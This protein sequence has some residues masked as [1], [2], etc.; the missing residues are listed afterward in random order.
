MIKTE[1]IPPLYF[2]LIFYSMNLNTNILEI[3]FKVIWNWSAIVCFS[4]CLPVYLAKKCWIQS[5]DLFY[6]QIFR[7]HSMKLIK[8]ILCVCYLPTAVCCILSAACFLISTACYL[9][10]AVFFLLSAA[11]SLLLRELYIWLHNFIM[12][13]S[14]WLSR[15]LKC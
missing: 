12:W 7:Y 1:F 2:A 6:I 3:N 9:M 8:N 5:L 14:L 11:C 15:Y 4:R 13:H 10:S